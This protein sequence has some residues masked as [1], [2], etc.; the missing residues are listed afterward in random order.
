MYVRFDS[1][2]IFMVGCKAIIEEHAFVKIVKKKRVSMN[3]VH[4]CKIEHAFVKKKKS[5]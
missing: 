5:A 1:I 2:H 4:I 3:K